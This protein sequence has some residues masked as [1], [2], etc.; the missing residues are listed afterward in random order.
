MRGRPE[1]DWARYVTAEPPDEMLTSALIYGFS[2]IVVYRKGYADAGAGIEQELSQLLGQK[3]IVSPDGNK[4]FFDFPD[5]LREA[6][7]DSAG[8]TYGTPMRP[9]WLDYGQDFYPEE[10]VAGD[11]WR[12]AGGASNIIVNN[13]NARAI[14][15]TLSFT[16][17]GISI[18]GGTVSVLVDGFKPTILDLPSS[19]SP[20]RLHTTFPPGRTIV[21]LRPSYA[22]ERLS[23]AD[24][25]HFVFRLKNPNVADDDGRFANHV[26]DFVKRL[27]AWHEHSQLPMGVTGPV[28][29]LYL[30]NPCCWL[31]KRTMFRVSMPAM[32]RNLRFD[33]FQ[34][35]I[36]ELAD[37]TQSVSITV[38]DARPVSFVVPLGISSLRVA[39]SRMRKSRLLNVSIRPKVYF[40]PQHENGSADTRILSLYL[41]EVDAW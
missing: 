19:G 6:S 15:G 11:R 21:R 36:S 16:M 35:A 22:P 24:S 40:V 18:P 25:R 37:E 28:S 3:P 39:V 30:D 7:L 2:G 38:G 13:D 10:S 27:A 32:A 4:S 17:M 12:W 26:A 29:G 1:G 14:A 8:K 5:V 41:R 9:L 31:S 23:L 33:L 20:F 34:P